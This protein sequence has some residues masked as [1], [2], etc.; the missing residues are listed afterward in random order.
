MRKKSLWF[1]LILFFTIVSLFGC[2]MGPPVKNLQITK[3]NLPTRHLIENVPTYRQ[4]YM[5][6]GPTSLHMVLNF[7]GMN[8]SQEEVGRV[9]R[10]RG[11]TVSDMESYPR[12][13]GF[14]VYSFY[15]WRKEEIKYLLAQGYPLVVLGVPP[16]E[17]YKT[18][19]YSGE[20]HY[21]VVVGYDDQKK[22]FIVHDPSP[23]RKIEISYEVFKD[24]HR[25]HP[26]HDNYVL[27][28]YPKR[29]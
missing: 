12:G 3:S 8:L 15:D 11:T 13:Q 26:T 22:I 5:D 9:R 19:R 25:S 27:C 20:G 18:G 28:I 24:F 14:E 21:V 1:Y 16:P 29:K 4:P 6:C 23:G 10:G 7:Y 2:A 17:W